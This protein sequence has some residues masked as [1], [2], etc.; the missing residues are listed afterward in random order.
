MLLC[1]HSNLCS[2]GDSR[3]EHD[4]L[5][6]SQRK[7]HF[8]SENDALLDNKMKMFEL[9]LVYFQTKIGKDILQCPN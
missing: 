5:T 3:Q 7:T 9:K 4:I 6:L 8:L 1:C 2:A